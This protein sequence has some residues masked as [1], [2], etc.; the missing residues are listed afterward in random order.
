MQ[1]STLTDELFSQDGRHNRALEYR[2][3]IAATDPLKCG[4]HSSSFQIVGTYQPCVLS[5]HNAFCR[6]CVNSQ[7]FAPSQLYN[8]NVM[9][10]TLRRPPLLPSMLLRRC[11]PLQFQLRHLC[12]VAVEDTN[13][14]GALLVQLTSRCSVSLS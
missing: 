9:R 1:V 4:S 14:F 11:R 6:V 13:R 12:R 10:V 7:G 8:P 3:L 2:T 5:P